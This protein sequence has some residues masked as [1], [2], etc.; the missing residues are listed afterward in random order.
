MYQMATWAETLICCEEW[1]IAHHTTLYSN[2]SMSEMRPSDHSQVGIRMIAPEAMVKTAI[3]AAV[4]A[5]KVTSG[6]EPWYVPSSLA[7]TSVAKKIATPISAP[8]ANRI[9]ER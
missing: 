8:T 3:M 4:S 6:N 2:G 9:S 7:I 5:P 1:P